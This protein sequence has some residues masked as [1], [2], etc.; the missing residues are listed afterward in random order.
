MAATP[1]LDVK[2][3]TKV[4]DMDTKSVE[5]V[6][7]PA[8]AFHELMEILNHVNI[9]FMMTLAVETSREHVA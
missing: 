3:A 9:I 4:N 6:K 1:C 7:L 8:L 2:V 5:I